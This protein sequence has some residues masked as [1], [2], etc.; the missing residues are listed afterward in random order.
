MSKKYQRLNL[1]ERIRIEIGLSH[2]KS[3]GEIAAELGRSKSTISREVSP[4]TKQKYNA[5]KSHQYAE[6]CSSLR[7]KNKQKIVLRSSISDYICEKLHLRWSPEQ[8]SKSLKNEFPNDTSM[9]VSHETIYRYLYLHCKKNIAG[10]TNKTT[11]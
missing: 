1:S 6:R 2:S 7:K 11:S 3:L 4:W 9:H 8:I 10:R 5:L